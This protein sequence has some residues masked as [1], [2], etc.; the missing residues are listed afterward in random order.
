MLNRESSRPELV[1][2][3]IRCYPNIVNY[4]TVLSK[5]KVVPPFK[6]MFPVFIACEIV[7]ME[8]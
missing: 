8:I 7:N 5:Q 1:P 6:D 3:Y 4:D 2:N